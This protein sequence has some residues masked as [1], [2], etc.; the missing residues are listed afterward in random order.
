MLEK[1]V[2]E[3]SR[4]IDIHKEVETSL[5][6]KNRRLNNLLKKGGDRKN[7][8]L[9]EDTYNNLSNVDSHSRSLA[10]LNAN[11]DF[12]LINNLEKKVMK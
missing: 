5:A 6:E 8:L 11:R 4:D 10:N 9:E 2:F 7:S 12:S 3:L 1:K